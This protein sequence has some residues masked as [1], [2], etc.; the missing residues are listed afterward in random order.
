MKAKTPRVR[1]EPSRI[2]VF[3]PAMKLVGVC[4]SMTAA[5]Q[6]LKVSTSAIHFACNG[7]TPSCQGWYVRELDNVIIEFPDDLGTLR[8]EDFDNLNGTKRTTYPDRGTRK[9]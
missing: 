2:A 5:A 1:R 3:S 6:M 9:I 7:K 4:A 8:L